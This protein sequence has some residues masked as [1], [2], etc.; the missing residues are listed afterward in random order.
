MKTTNDL[1][2]ECLARISAKTPEARE[3]EE[4]Q[5]LRDAAASA[6]QPAQY[7]HYIAVL[8]EPNAGTPFRERS[9]KT[10]SEAS[11]WRDENQPGAKVRLCETRIIDGATTITMP[12]APEEGMQSP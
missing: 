2:D 4:K 11:F 5:M 6:S 12:V 8:G 3:Q 1:I 10:Y 7:T 9:F